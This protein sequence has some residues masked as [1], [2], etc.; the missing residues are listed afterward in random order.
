MSFKIG[1]REIGIDKKPFIIAEMSGNHNQSLEKA[2]E[3]VELAAKSGVDALKIQTFTADTITLNV[4]QGEFFIDNPNNLWKGQ[5]LYELYDKAHTPWEWH[6]A[7]FDKCRE[8]GIIG[9]STP[10]DCTAVDFLESLNVPCYKIASFELTNIPLIK[11]V[12]STG[13]PMIISTGMSTISEIAETVDI[14]TQYGC[15]DIVLL[16][17][18]S[19][20]PASPKDTN[21]FTIEHMKKTFGCEV[22]ISDHTLGIGVSI[23]SIPLGATIIEKHFTSDRKDGGVDAVFSMEPNEF[24]MLVEESERAW[25]SLGTVKYGF[26]ESEKES[27]KYRQSIYLSEDVIAG[28]IITK[29]NIRVIRPGLGLEPKFFEVVLGM[30]ISK[31]LKKGTPLNWDMVK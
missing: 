31:N 3:I 25:Q 19:S 27:L 14:A 23:A 21:I 26:T 22:G 13:K 1:T 16:K 12:A 10:F 15:K 9:F 2:L 5:T 17:C 20:Y 8:F 4:N 29:N 18:T 6:E 28:E 24:K 11:K 30:R 7:I